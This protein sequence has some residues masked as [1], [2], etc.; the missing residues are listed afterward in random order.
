MGLGGD[1]ALSGGH[2]CKHWG[3]LAFAVPAVAALILGSSYRRQRDGTS[4]VRKDPD[5]VRYQINQLAF[6]SGGPFGVG[7]EA[8]ANRSYSSCR[9]RIPTLCWLWSEKSWA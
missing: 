1:I 3:M 8:K 2:A 9:K 7:L 4:S 6:G 5:R